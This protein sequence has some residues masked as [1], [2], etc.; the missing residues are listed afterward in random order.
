MKAS[1]LYTKRVINHFHKQFITSMI[2]QIGTSIATIGTGG[3]GLPSA[4]TKTATGLINALQQHY[5]KGGS[6]LSGMNNLPLPQSI[7]IIWER[8]EVQSDPYEY[9]GRPDPHS[10]MLSNLHGYTEIDR[11]S[12]E[13][14]LSFATKEETDE[15]RNLLQ[16]GV[17]LP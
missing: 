9:K 8:N 13:I 4:I 14:D 6:A 12:D 10:T 2:G 16:T 7:Y 5:N 3:K 11:F 15:L 17:Y 1:F